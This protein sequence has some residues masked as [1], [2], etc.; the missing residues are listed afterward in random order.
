MARLRPATHA[1][2]TAAQLSRPHLIVAQRCRTLV[3]GGREVAAAEEREDLP[4]DLVAGESVIKCPPPSAM[5]VYIFELVP[6]EVG[7]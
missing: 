6:M 5:N 7:T 3:V 4:G 1:H 2:A